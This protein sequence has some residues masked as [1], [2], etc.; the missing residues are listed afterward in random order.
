MTITHDTPVGN[1]IPA[2]SILKAVALTPLAL[3]R[4]LSR[5]GWAT[6]HKQAVARLSQ[7]LKRDIGE[8]DHIPL[9]GSNPL[10]KQP[11]YQERLEA[12]WQR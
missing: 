9:P 8:I 4:N 11:T 5:L 12:M 7:H 3:L 6:S 2:A 10:P 1:D